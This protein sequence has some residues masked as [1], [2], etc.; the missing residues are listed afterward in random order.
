M[1]ARRIASIIRHIESPS[2]F[3]AIEGSKL[4]TKKQV[5]IT[6]FVGGN[7]PKNAMVPTIDLVAMYSLVSA[8]LGTGIP[9]KISR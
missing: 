1:D 5:K 4:I 2:H 3:E 7:I 9:L 8:F 6:Q